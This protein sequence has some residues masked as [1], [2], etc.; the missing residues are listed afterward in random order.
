MSELYYIKNEKTYYYLNSKG[1]WNRNIKAYK[2][3]SF[4]TKE[5]AEAAVP[6]G[7]NC[8]IEKSVKKNKKPLEN[9]FYVLFFK[10]KLLDKNNEFSILHKKDKEVFRF[11]S[12]E[13]AI[14]KAD[15]LNLDMDHVYIDNINK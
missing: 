7:V 5:E 10:G 14:N 9:V 8:I 4:A 2:L 6:A 12:E 11:E 1:G 15:S 13:D 3:V